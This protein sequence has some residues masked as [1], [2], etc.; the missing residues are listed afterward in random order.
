MRLRSNAEL[1]CAAGQTARVMTGMC[2]PPPPQ[3][4]SRYRV[5]G[6]AEGAGQRLVAFDCAN[7]S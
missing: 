5:N 7:Y 2:Q 1:R 6:S 4:V 3:G